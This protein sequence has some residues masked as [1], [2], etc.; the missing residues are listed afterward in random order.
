M[1][2]LSHRAQTQERLHDQLSPAVI[3]VAI[4]PHQKKAHLKRAERVV[5]TADI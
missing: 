4:D 3:G 2:F 1:D 5:I